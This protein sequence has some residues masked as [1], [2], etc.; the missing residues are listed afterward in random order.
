MHYRLSVIKKKKIKHLLKADNSDNHHGNNH[1]QTS[2]GRAH[3]ERQLV[4]HRLL[5]V[6]FTHTQQTSALERLKLGLFICD[7]RQLAL[8]VTTVRPEPSLVGSVT[9]NRQAS[10]VEPS[11]RVCVC[12]WSYCSGWWCWSPWG[13]CSVRIRPR[14]ELWPAPRRGWLLSDRPPWLSCAGL[15]L[16]ETWSDPGGEEKKNR[17]V[18]FF[19]W[20]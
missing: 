4:L 2:G 6:T 15:W 1:H 11:A 19:K 17:N 12:G 16:C 8:A 9:G 14:C 3:D 20:W 7:R 13:C 5:R 10:P 18:F